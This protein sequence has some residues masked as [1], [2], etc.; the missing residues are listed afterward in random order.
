M[1]PIVKVL[2]GLSPQE[3]YQKHLQIVHNFLPAQL[4]NK[5]IEV[6]ALFMSLKGELAEQDRFGTQC[7]K[8][9]MRKLSL[10]PGG[11]GN[12]L[13]ALEDK[14]YISKQGKVY[15]I[16]P[17]LIPSGESRQGYQFLIEK[18]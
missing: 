15:R 1:K 5:E 8:V 17:F 13:R 9:V 7:R 10:R 11:L 3:Y 16:V 18:I 2:R 4:T 14:G 12:H 6:L